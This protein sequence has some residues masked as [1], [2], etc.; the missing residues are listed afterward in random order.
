[1][2]DPLKEPGPSPIPFAAPNPA[3]TPPDLAS[4]QIPPFPN[5]A[6]VSAPSPAQPPNQSA[7][8]SKVYVIIIA[9]ILVVAAVAGA[10]FLIYPKF[11][12]K[13]SET[14]NS[15]ADIQTIKKV[16]P[17]PNEIQSTPSAQP[18]T[19]NPK[20][21]SSDFSLIG[22][23]DWTK[24]SG[25][26]GSVILFQNAVADIDTNGQS[27]GASIAVST[28]FL[29]ND[30]TLDEYQKATIIQRQ[31][32]LNGYKLLSQTKGT[33]GGQVANVDVYQAK[34]GNID[35]KQGQMYT[36]KNHKAYVIT[37]HALANSWDK[38]AQIFNTTAQ[39]FQL[40]GK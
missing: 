21:E 28:D 6:P 35:E 2:P 22:P 18:Q 3:Q 17:T 32:T 36:I 9:I 25:S 30:M 37:F 13:Q 38:Y 40:I 10:I 16:Q 5:S 24:V 31:N 1:M 15:Q 19:K 33:L 7:P 11:I 26:A 4:A 8:K 23:T 27:F 34:I 29:Q 12:K 20:F 14:P 39:S